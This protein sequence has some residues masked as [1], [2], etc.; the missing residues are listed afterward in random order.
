[1]LEVK[2][3]ELVEGCM[4]KKIEVGDWIDLYAAD[5]VIM[6][7]GDIKYIP[8]GVAMELPKGYE[9][10]VASRSSVAK[11]WGLIAINGIGI[12]DNSFNGDEDEWM[13]PVYATRHAYIEKGTRLCQFRIIKNQEE[14]DFNKCT[15]L[16]NENRG[17]YG[18]TG[19]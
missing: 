1:M 12:I 9:A 15:S 8:L 3:N 16:G 10:I 13:W 19:L 11:N 18:S 14:I 4:P 7:P 2:V 17:G 5:D 6:N